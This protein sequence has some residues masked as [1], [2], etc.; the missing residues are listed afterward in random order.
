MLSRLS[1]IRAFAPDQTIQLV[2]K[3]DLSK[4]EIFVNGV[5]FASFLYRLKPENVSH[6]R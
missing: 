3:A 5:K 2:I 6:V 1:L 4:F